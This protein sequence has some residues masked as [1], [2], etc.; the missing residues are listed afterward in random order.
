MVY[1]FFK[2]KYGG[3]HPPR[4]VRARASSPIF[5]FKLIFYK[6]YF[7]LTFLIWFWEE[8]EKVLWKRGVSWT[9]GQGW[10]RSGFMHLT[11]KSRM[12]LIIN[13]YG[14]EVEMFRKALWVESFRHAQNRSGGGIYRPLEN[15]TVAGSK[16]LQSRIWISEPNCIFADHVTGNVTGVNLKRSVVF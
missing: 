8:E 7:Y 9:L 16:Q 4:L 3:I 11:K 13:S 1:I 2:K 10:R 14:R 15:A 12:V 5:F 6:L